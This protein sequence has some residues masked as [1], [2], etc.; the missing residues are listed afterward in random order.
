MFIINPHRR[1]AKRL[2]KTSSNTSSINNAISEYNKLKTLIEKQEKPVTDLQKK[3]LAN[4]KKNVA[5][6]IGG[7][8]KYTKKQNNKTRKVKKSRKSKKSKK[9]R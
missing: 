6:L 1:T 2:T 3:M 9:L 4:L 7:K 8:R 5:S